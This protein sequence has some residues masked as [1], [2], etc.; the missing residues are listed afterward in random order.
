[1][2]LSRTPSRAL[3]AL[4]FVAALAA[5]P[6]SAVVGPQTK[7][8]PLFVAGELIVN[9]RAGASVVERDAQMVRLGA[10]SGGRVGR[11]GAQLLRL[12]RDADLRS[13]IARLRASGLVES[14]TRVSLKRELEACSAIVAPKLCPNDPDFTADHQYG[15]HNEFNDADMDL[16]EAWVVVNNANG[17]LVAIADDGFNLTHEDLA[18]DLRSGTNCENDPCVGTAASQNANA[19]SH[20]SIVAGSAAGRGNNA[21]GIA[22]P[23][24]NG[25]VLPIRLGESFTDPALVRA[26]EFATTNDADILNLSLGGP[27]FTQAES[28]ALDPSTTTGMLIVASAGNDDSSIDKSVDHYPANYDLPNVIAIA[29][30]NDRD[31]IAPFS[32]W[33]PTRVDLAAPGTSIRS[34][35]TGGNS[36][37]TYANGTSFSAPYTAGV[38][39]LVGQRLIDLG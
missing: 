14:A 29:A 26:Y 20:G 9:W 24:L 12:G 36:N 11:G 34:A 6:V 22:S 30:S 4:A 16:P 3:A 37:Y 19:E 7:Q 39:A 17:V 15:L 10:L 32:I 13:A 2:T 5:L 28:D 21:L 8:R 1:M 35:W 25:D 33:G 18:P 31:R 38:A 27:V 23:V